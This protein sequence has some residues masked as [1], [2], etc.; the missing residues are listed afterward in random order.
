MLEYS[1]SFE[2]ESDFD[3]ICSNINYYF[4]RIQ[5]ALLSEKYPDCIISFRAVVCIYVLQEFQRKCH[6]FKIHV[7]LPYLIAS[8]P[9]SFG[10]M[11]L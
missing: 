1:E 2:I 7:P 5:I 11:N 4:H 9:K 3:K 10:A 6:I 8:H